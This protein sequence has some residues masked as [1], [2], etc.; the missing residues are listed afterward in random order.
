MSIVHRNEKRKLLRFS[1]LRWTTT[2]LLRTYSEVSLRTVE[3]RVKLS[4]TLNQNLEART[5]QAC[6]SCNEHLVV[7]AEFW[8]Q[9]SNPSKAKLTVV[10]QT[11]S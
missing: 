3:F 10:L 5:E 7:H 4:G 9:T 11:K 8:S 6:A 1:I 2:V